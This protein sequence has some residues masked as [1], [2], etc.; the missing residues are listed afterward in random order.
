[1]LAEF[2]RFA[3]GITP[4]QAQAKVEELLQSGQMSQEQFENL[5]KQ[6]QDFMEFLK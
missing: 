3:S 5:K 1:M 2:R 6:A 4:Q